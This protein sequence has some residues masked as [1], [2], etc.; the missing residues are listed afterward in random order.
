MAMVTSIITSITIN[1]LSTLKVRFSNLEGKRKQTTHSN[2]KHEFLSV[3]SCKQAASFIIF[4]LCFGLVEK[5]YIL[6][7]VYV[8][9]I[10]NE[11]QNISCLSTLHE[12]ELFF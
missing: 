12:L 6:F 7:T 10:N 11:K 8:S 1:G 5:G 9:Q 2:S 4:T 3:N